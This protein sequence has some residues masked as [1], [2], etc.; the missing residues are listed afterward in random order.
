M[1][2][3]IQTYGSPPQEKHVFFL[4][5]PELP[6]PPPHPFRAMPKKNFFWEVFPYF[7]NLHL[8][9]FKGFPCFALLRSKKILLQKVSQFI[10]KNKNENDLI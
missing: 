6:P 2:S 7:N 9:H 5:L 8:M 1:C 3:G 10:L 4:A